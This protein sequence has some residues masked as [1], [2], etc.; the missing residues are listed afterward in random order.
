MIVGV[1]HVHFGSQSYSRVDAVGEMVGMM[2]LAKAGDI[3]EAH[4]YLE[5]SSTG[6]TDVNVSIQSTVPDGNGVEPSGTDLSSV[7]NLTIG[8]GGG[9][10]TVTFATPATVTAGQVVALVI[11]CTAT[12]GQIDVYYPD[13]VD[14]KNWAAY[15]RFY[16]GSSWGGVVGIHLL[17]LGIVYDDGSAPSISGLVPYERG[18]NQLCRTSTV[19]DE[20]GIKFTAPFR[21]SLAGIRAGIYGIGS[22]TVT[23][24]N[25]VDAVIASATYDGEEDG[26]GTTELSARLFP[27]VTL[28]DGRVYRITVL[29]ADANGASLRTYYFATTMSAAELATASPFYAINTTRD[30]GGSWT[31]DT[32]RFAAIWPVFNDV[33][34]GRIT[35]HPG[36]VG[37][38][39]G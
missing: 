21:A 18:N 16:N 6:S 30:E 8:A 36:M 27:P 32:T 35:Q 12:T 5:T 31:D 4:F 13:D 9:W 17:S 15:L 2:F 37:G 1:N 39:H 29:G 11:D 23:V 10:E 26:V 19:P 14:D 24:Y 33:S 7:E 28:I 22:H 20:V 38:V 25:D 34:V 3:E